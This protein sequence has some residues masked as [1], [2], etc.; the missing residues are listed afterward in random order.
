MIQFSAFIK[1][2][3]ENMPNQMTPGPADP[4]DPEGPP[5]LHL[6]NEI[7]Y[8]ILL[9]LCPPSPN[10]LLPPSD[11]RTE[12][13]IS[14][15][16]A[17]KYCYVV[18]SQ[19][20]RKHC[21]FLDSHRRITR[22]LRS[23]GS[24]P[25]YF[26]KNGA[27]SASIKLGIR[28]TSNL[29]LRPFPLDAHP[30]PVAPDNAELDT[31]TSIAARDRELSFEE[32]LP[33]FLENSSRMA[34]I[35]MRMI[36]SACGDS[37]RRLV[38]DLPLKYMAPPPQNADVHNEITMSIQRLRKLKEFVLMQDERYFRAFPQWPQVTVPPNWVHVWPC[39]YPLLY[40]NPLPDRH[41]DIWM[42]MDHV[43]HREL[44]IFMGYG[45][46]ARDGLQAKLVWLEN[47]DTA[48]EPHVSQGGTPMPKEHARMWH[49]NL[50]IVN[51]DAHLDED[52]Y[53]C[54]L[55]WDTIG[56]SGRVRSLSARRIEVCPDERGVIRQVNYFRNFPWQLCDPDYIFPLTTSVV[57]SS[58][59]SI[60]MNTFI[61]WAIWMTAE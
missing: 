14:A 25:P 3:S 12:A 45:G 51:V 54:P 5:G 52:F 11:P 8:N 31:S 60:S 33:R 32:M 17:N 28:A 38:L 46:I 1:E 26:V 56:S 48:N 2:A 61:R 53:K 18:A 44:A 40:Y 49:R 57:S 43:P 24:S 34:V 59:D 29:F 10:G 27:Y 50:T 35:S 36:L 55:N 13:L 58:A 19:F 39:L 15:A 4:D 47:A 41:A 22:F 16:R 7:I 20:I 42:D 9:Q 23:A 37:L 6:P 30:Y 21:V